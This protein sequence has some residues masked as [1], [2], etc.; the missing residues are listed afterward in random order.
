[1]KRHADSRSPFFLGILSIVGFCWAGI[2]LG[3]AEEVQVFVP[4]V[5]GR[6]VSLDGILPADVLARVLL[7]KEKVEQIRFELGKPVNR[8]GNV[9]V[10]GAQP[11]E[12]FFQAV[13][14]FQKC[15]RLAF[16]LT[17]Q[18][19]IKPDIPPVD[20]IR[21][22]HVYGV[23]NTASDR[24]RLI[25]E[26]LGSSD[27]VIE[28]EMPIETEPSEVFQAI[29]EVNQQLN[30]MLERRFAPADVY[31]EVTLG[32]GYASRLL[33]RFP[34]AQRI[35]PAPAY[36]RGKRPSD[37]YRR[38]LGCYQRLQK[39]GAALDTA[40]V[41]FHP[42]ETDIADAAPSDVYDVASLI[43][44]ELA[45]LHAKSGTEPPPGDYYAGRKFPSHV[46]QRAGILETQLD[47]L[48]RL[49]EANPGWLKQ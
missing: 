22:F 33:S 45:Y 21:P 39:I 24:V 3:W 7:V 48:E 44:S 36:E 9:R 42:Q 47:A 27:E 23:V 17:G 4:P 10:E 2:G 1:M 11:R 16:E 49:T 20:R 38:L 28:R 5:S 19:G 35:P 12:V 18:L 13:T 29:V 32:I 34:E 8:R 15:D 43:V 31:R 14:L 6:E 46:Y 37:V 25:R 30:L 26:A 41:Q 40:M